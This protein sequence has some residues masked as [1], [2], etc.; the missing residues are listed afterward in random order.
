MKTLDSVFTPE[1][2]ALFKE[3]LTIFFQNEPLPLLE[4]NAIRIDLFRTAHGDRYRIQVEDA[5]LRQKI[6]NYFQ[7]QENRV[8]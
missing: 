5:E 7:E 4:S 2:F 3:Q 6:N 1:E 8:M